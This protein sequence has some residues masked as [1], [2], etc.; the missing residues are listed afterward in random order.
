MKKIA[1]FLNVL[2][3]A[4]ICVAQKQ[5]Y[6]FDFS[7]DK[8]VKEGY[9]K[10]TPQTLFNNEQGYGYDLQPAWDGKSNKPF[11]FSVNVPDGNYKVTVVIGSKNEPSST[12]VR[13]E[14]RRLFIENLSTK[15]GE[16]KT[17]TFTIN[18]R[19]IKISGKERVR[20]KSREK[21]KLNWDDK[22][23]LEFNG[24]SPRLNSLI[25]EPVE[26]VPTVYLCG[27]STVVDYDNEPWGA[28]GQM[29]P[30]FFTDKVCIA[31]HAESGLSANTFISGNRLKKIMSQI[32]KG[33]YLLVEFGHNDQKQKQPGTGA[34][35]SF[36]YNL[37]IFIDEA[38][39]KG[40]NPVLVTP[41]CRRR[42]DKEGKS[43]NTHGEY[44][45]AIRWV[46]QKENVPLIELNGMTT[47]LCDALGVDGSMKLYVHY[48]AGTFPGQTRE[49]KDNSHF[50][51]Y[52]AYETAKCVVEG[53]KKAKLDIA[54]YLRADYKGFNPAQPDKFETFKWNLCP[55]TEIE[56]PD[57]N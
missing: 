17:E 18:K 26:N 1:L 54:N 41:T 30:R 4:T 55:F 48:P 31:N 16:L 56:K 7:S 3:V 49:F 42:F 24:E 8:K 43:V 32:K 36:V 47:M 20:I 22:L 50:S 21:N 45:D 46:A 57:G 10:V 23:T 34:Y 27:N 12:T 15:K 37:K 33:D 6:K 44:P 5:T 40:A 29:I 38:R 11:F 51:T 35:F 28:W 39:A 53:M 14:S 13:G 25:I 2:L 19:N 52:G 9:L